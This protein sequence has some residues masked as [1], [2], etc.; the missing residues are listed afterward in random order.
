[1]LRAIIKDPYIFLIHNLSLTNLKQRGCLFKTAS[2]ENNKNLL[3]HLFTK[4]DSS[5]W[6]NGIVSQHF[7]YTN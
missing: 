5:I 1:M 2:I 4:T 6:E 7:F 3:I